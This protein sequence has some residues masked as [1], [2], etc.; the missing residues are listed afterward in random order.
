[1]LLD[2]SVTRR[3]TFIPPDPFGRK[4][5]EFRRRSEIAVHL[6]EQKD[7]GSAYDQD[8]RTEQRDDGP[9]G[10][11]PQVSAQSA[12]TRLVEL[13]DKFTKE[14]GIWQISTL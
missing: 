11:G 7:E 3:G 13:I 8:S 12:E 5:L 4:V 14:T 2:D 9:Q 1:M 6:M 10:R